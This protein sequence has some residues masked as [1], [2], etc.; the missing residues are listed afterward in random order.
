MKWE[1]DV[2]V[3]GTGVYG[4]TD[5][6]KAGKDGWEL[7]SID[8]GTAYFKRPVEDKQ[9]SQP[10]AKEV[11]DTGIV[12]VRCRNCGSG[13]RDC[14]CGKPRGPGAPLGPRGGDSNPFPGCPS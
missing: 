4:R 8:Q 5:L 9:V 12:L 13:I 6:Q 11:G 7:V 14:Y 10:V 3:V 1:Y 2:V